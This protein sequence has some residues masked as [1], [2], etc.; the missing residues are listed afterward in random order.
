MYKKNISEIDNTK[1]EV[2]QNTQ[3]DIYREYFA[4]VCCMAMNSTPSLPANT[5]T[6]ADNLETFNTE[7]LGLY[8]A[9]I[10]STVDSHYT[11]VKEH[12]LLQLLEE[13]E[14][15]E[16]QQE[17][18][19]KTNIN[20]NLSHVRTLKQLSSNTDG[21][22]IKNGYH[23]SSYTNYLLCF[24]HGDL[25][26]FR[27]LPDLKV[28]LDKKKK[29]AADKAAAEKEAADKAAA[30]KEVAD[31]AA[32]EKE[33]ADKAA[34]DKAAADKAAAEKEAADKAAADK[35]AADKAAADKAAA[36][37]AAADKA[38][39]DKAAADKAAADKAAAPPKKWDT[40]QTTSGFRGT[41]TAGISGT[42]TGIGSQSKTLKNMHQEASISS[43]RLK[44]FTGGRT[45]RK[46]RKGN[47]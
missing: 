17:Y 12:N 39:A 36:D 47:L 32:A 31:K 4:R 14:G 15:F 18:I 44:V 1:P 5:Y 38:A 23:L 11:S 24:T 7:T 13:F 9:Y 16:T 34:A 19:N 41:G 3:Y 25:D 45:R 20:E 8:K 28:S 30:E 46:N 6:T 42:P 10:G 40:V 29:A 27:F 35:A 2:G 21:D 26:I 37:K 43:R 22:W 33:A